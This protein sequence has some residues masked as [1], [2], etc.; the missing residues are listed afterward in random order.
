MVARA[1]A[2]LHK[3]NLKYAFATTVDHDIVEPTCFSQ[4]N[5]VS[6]WRMAMADEFNVFQKN[7]TLVFGAISTQYEYSSQQMGLQ[8]QAS[9]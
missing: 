9:F 1:K 8:N 6:E 7:G 3:S 5:K 4:A 2:A